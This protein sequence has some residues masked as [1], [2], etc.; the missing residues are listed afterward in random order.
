MDKYEW[1]KKQFPTMVDKKLR[2]LRKQNSAATYEQ[3]LRTTAAELP[4][5]Y[6]DY[7]R[8]VGSG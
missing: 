3:A 5:V 4:D 2:E 7:V 6:E 1:A 8:S